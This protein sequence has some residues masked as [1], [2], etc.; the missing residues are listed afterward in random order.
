MKSKIIRSN[1]KT[2]SIQILGGEIVVKV[3][4]QVHDSVVE[5][6][7]KKN[8]AWIQK[9]LEGYT[10]MGYRLKQ[11]ILIY[12]ERF[13][14]ELIEG[15]SFKKNLHNGLL[16]ITVPK[17]KEEAWI[18]QK[19]DDSFKDSLSRYIE[20][21]LPYYCELLNI[22]VPKFKVRRYKRIHGRCSSKGEL[23]FNL[24]LYH[25][26]K[27]FIDYVILHECAHLLEF[28]HSKKFYALIEKI[29]PDYKLR[30]KMQKTSR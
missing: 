29:M 19:V 30:I 1:R 28:N 24:Y 14:T 13:E 18:E 10:P 25:E 5:A 9:R 6:F 27:R 3:P 23:A 22:P 16:R 17:N 15:P 12:G 7:I 8:E 2:L 4:Y 20:N 11:A 21:R 26:D